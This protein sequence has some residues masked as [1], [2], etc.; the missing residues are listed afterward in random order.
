MLDHSKLPNLYATV[1]E[2]EAMLPGTHFFTSNGHLAAGLG[3]SV[4]Y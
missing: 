1:N 3:E 4:S 2:L